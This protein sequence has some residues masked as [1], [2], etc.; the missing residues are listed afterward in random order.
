MVSIIRWNLAKWKLRH[1]AQWWPAR[2][3]LGQPASEPESWELKTRQLS[4]VKC[5]TSQHRNTYQG[6]TAL[7]WNSRSG[8]V[9]PA[10]IWGVFLMYAFIFKVF[11]FKKQKYFFSSP[12]KIHKKEGS[13]CNQ[14]ENSQKSTKLQMEHQF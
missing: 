6:H 14:I 2:L 10:Q 4:P 1:M 5:Q 13:L 12:S 11:I 8:Y 9:R 3:S 7:K